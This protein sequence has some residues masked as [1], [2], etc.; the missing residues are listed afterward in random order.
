LPIQFHADGFGIFTPGLEVAAKRMKEHDALGLGRESSRTKERCRQENNERRSRA[1]TPDV[2]P[3]DYALRKASMHT[4][5]VVNKSSLHLEA[6]A[7]QSS[8]DLNRVARH[9]RE[10]HRRVAC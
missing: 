10:R 5:L 1:D 3:H 9:R 6:I 7:A 4:G 2:P 8:V